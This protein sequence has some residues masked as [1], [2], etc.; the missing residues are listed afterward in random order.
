[1][2]DGERQEE[3]ERKKTEKKNQTSSLSAALET[4]TNSLSLS[5]SLSLSSLSLSLSAPY[6]NE[7]KSWCASILPP[8]KGAS[9]G[10]VFIAKIVA[11]RVGERARTR[12]EISRCLFLFCGRREQKEQ[13]FYA[14]FLI[15]V[16]W[17]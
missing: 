1:M 14:L 11:S 9:M 15:V 12:R 2:N 4:F 10:H 17:R 8:K 3:K 7:R 13:V 5:L 16:G 6:S